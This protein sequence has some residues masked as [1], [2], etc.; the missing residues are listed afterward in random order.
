[1]S[2]VINL[3]LAVLACAVVSTSAVAAATR[4]GDTWVYYHFDGVG[5]KAGPS[6]DEK[7]FVAIREGARPVVLLTRTSE[8]ES[9]DLPEGA[10]AISG[11]CYIQSSGG[12]LGGGSEYVPCPKVPLLVSAGGKQLVTVQTDEHGYFVVVLAEGTYS[13]GSGP[14]TAE[15]PVERGITS[16]VPLRAGKR[17]VD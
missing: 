15:I 2:G 10:G 7:P 11:I 9:I 6:S 14:F 1:M 8:I 13:I 5:F 12:K 16:L 17:M 4:P 3:L